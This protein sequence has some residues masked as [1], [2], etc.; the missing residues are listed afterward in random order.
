[1]D[2]IRELTQGLKEEIFTEEL[3]PKLARLDVILATE[4]LELEAESLDG[5]LAGIDEA[6]ARVS[7]EARQELEAIGDFVR[8]A[9]KG[10]GKAIG[11]AKGKVKAAKSFGRSVKHA[12]RSGHSAGQKSGYG[13]GSPGGGAH[14]KGGM[15]KK[16]AMKHKMVRRNPK[17]TKPG[18]K[19]AGMRSFKLHR[20]HPKKPAGGKPMGKKKHLKLVAS[21]DLPNNDIAE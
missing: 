18:A 10:A 6:M 20:P 7:P 19:K 8:K 1:M 11:Y 4:G 2:S 9:A 21:N 17:A 5:L 15:A 12:F 3:A 14:K 13:G 16:P